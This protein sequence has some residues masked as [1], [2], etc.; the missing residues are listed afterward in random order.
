MNRMTTAK[1][2]LTAVLGILLLGLAVARPKPKPRQ[3]AGPNK[4]E[5]LD[6]GDK[7]KT[8]NVYL[9][10]DVNGFDP[11]AKAI[12]ECEFGGRADQKRD[13]T[14]FFRLQKIDGRWTLIDA[15]GHPF[16][17]TAINGIGLKSIGNGRRKIDPKAL[18]II[19]KAGFNATHISAS[20]LNQIGPNNVRVPYLSNLMFSHNYLMEHHRGDKLFWDAPPFWDEAMRKSM[21]ERAKA[22]MPTAKDDPCLIAW[23][24]DNEVHWPADAL[25]HYHELSQKTEPYTVTIKARGKKVDKSTYTIDPRKFKSY[26]IVADWVKENG[27][28]K[29]KDGFSWEA[30]MAFQEFQATQYAKLTSDVIKAIDRN[31]MIMGARHIRQDGQ[32]PGMFKGLGKYFDAMSINYYGAWPPDPVCLD[33]WERWSGR[34]TI[35]TEFSAQSWETIPRKARDAWIV[36]TQE[37]RGKYYQNAVLAT[38]QNPNCIGTLWFSYSDRG[39]QANYGIVDQH[40]KPYDVILRYMREVNTRRYALIDFL[41]QNPLDLA[42]VYDPLRNVKWR[43]KFEHFDY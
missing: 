39:D 16:H 26:R 2:Y 15:C 38:L 6:Y 37:D 8:G 25:D 23:L 12:S 29:G 41:K 20:E 19:Q 42:P 33:T 30:R 40:G 17:A 9:V 28:T 3:S 24:T 36:R 10:K 31:H 1:I 22:L 18:E 43:D 21:E 35:I 27:Y 13:A 11:D 4:A 5:F 32:N 34:P 14:G 7:W